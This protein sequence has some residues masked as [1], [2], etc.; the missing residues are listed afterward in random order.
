MLLANMS[1]ARRIHKAYPDQAILRCHP[2]PKEKSS[3][4]LVCI[5]IIIMYS[6]VLTRCY[7]P[8]AVTPPHIFE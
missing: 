6:I 8:F 3:E 7:A 2:C 1:V 4:I 5:M